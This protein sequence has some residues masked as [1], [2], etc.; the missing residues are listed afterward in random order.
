MIR[1]TWVQPEDLVAH[2]LVASAQEGRSVAPVAERWKAA[3]GSLD[4]AVSGATPRR[5][6]AELR[7]IARTLLEE[8]DTLAVPSELAEREPNDLETIRAGWAREM[9]VG[10]VAGG[11]L[12]ALAGRIHGAWLG[13]SAGCLLGKPVEKISREGIRAILESTGRW[14]LSYYFTERGL[15]PEIAE[16]YPWNRRSGPTS[17]EENIDGMPED[18][19]LNFPLIALSLLEESGQDFTTDDVA[20]AWLA[21]LPGGRV[22][23]AERIVY[24][25]LLLGHEPE[26]VATVQNPFREWIGA[27][28]RTDVYGWTNPGNPFRAA[29]LAWRDARLSHIRTGIYGAMFVAAA[30][31]AAVVADSVAEVIEAG[32]SVVPQDSRYAAGIRRAIEIA[33]S[34]KT[35]EDGIDAVYAEFGELH[36]VHAMN[37]SALTVFA[38]LRSEGDFENAITTAVSGGWDTDSNG[39]TVG[40]ICG[41]LAGADA[42][43]AR[44]IDPLRNRLASTLPGFSGIGFD[45][46][47]ARTLRVARNAGSA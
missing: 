17:L 3:G 30:C 10:A 13:R 16:R 2:E 11:K 32:L 9:S 42:L 24:R 44:W 19:D 20:K 25:N 15:A 41:A 4:A 6:S 1:L 33:R 22:F 18:D 8:L 45:E 46:L 26:V 7:T 38:L 40:S 27:Q 34:S 43:P 29:E 23:T 28:I 31:A 39:A 36:W 37:N 21:N 14:P 35:A 12:D 5:A 47:A